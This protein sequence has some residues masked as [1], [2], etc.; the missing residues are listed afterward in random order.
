MEILPIEIEQCIYKMYAK[1]YIFCEL[2]KK[3]FS[4]LVLTEMKIF[5]TGDHIGKM[6]DKYITARPRLEFTNAE[7]DQMYYMLLEAHMFNHID[8]FEYAIIDDIMDYFT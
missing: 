7:C 5:A 1:H 2:K 3:C 4:K 8:V 6:I